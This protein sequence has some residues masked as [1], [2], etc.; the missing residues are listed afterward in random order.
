MSRNG[1]QASGSVLPEGCNIVWLPNVEH[2]GCIGTPVNREVYTP[3]AFLAHAHL[4]SKSSHAAIAGLCLAGQAAALPMLIANN[5]SMAPWAMGAAFGAAAAIASWAG[6]KI[7]SRFA[8]K[9]RSGSG[10]ADLVLHDAF[11]LSLVLAASAVIGGLAAVL[12]LPAGAVLALAAGR[13][14]KGRAA[15][16]RGAILLLAVLIAM[17]G[18][19]APLGLQEAAAAA[20]ALAAIAVMKAGHARLRTPPGRVWQVWGAS[21]LLCAAIAEAGHGAPGVTGVAGLPLTLALAAGAIYG[22]AG[23]V[24]SQILRGA[25]AKA[26]AA[27]VPFLSA[28][29]IVASGG[30]IT[31]PGMAAALLLAATAAGLRRLAVAPRVPAVSSPNGWP[32]GWF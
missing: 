1:G 15:G 7:G 8:E 6:A 19:C 23:G 30:S 13:I 17:A 20:I 3:D 5:A 32:A 10:A 26:L 25:K 11:T 14:G 12:L 4:P 21:A 22:V 24:A 16:E 9:A 27:A 29:A 28:G 2:A 18:L 31:L